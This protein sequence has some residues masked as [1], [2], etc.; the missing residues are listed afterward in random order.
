MFRYI[1]K[2]K[3]EWLETKHLIDPITNENITESWI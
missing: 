2:E 3:K 1:K